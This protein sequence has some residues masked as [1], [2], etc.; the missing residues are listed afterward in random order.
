VVYRCFLDSRK[1]HLDVVP[2]DHLPEQASPAEPTETRLAVL[3]ALKKLPPRTRAVVVLRYWEDM[4]VE[5]TA[6]ILDISQG[7]VKLAAAGGAVLSVAAVIGTFALVTGA[8]PG[9]HGR[10]NPVQQVTSEPP[11]VKPT[12]ALGL[13]PQKVGIEKILDLRNRLPAA[14]QPLLP[15][16][17]SLAPVRYHQ[18][19]DR[20]GRPGIARGR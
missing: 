5:Q 8:T 15:P 1:R 4:S 12:G 19:G 11:P 6:A 3:E 10:P 17:I 7:S 20:V 14:L 18:P 16:G 9:R 2:L 13:Q